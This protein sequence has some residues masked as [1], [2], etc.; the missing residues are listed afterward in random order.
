M[1]I[2]NF[3]GGPIEILWI[4]FDGNL[5]PQTEKSIKPNN[6]A[7]INSYNTHKFQIRFENGKPHSQVVVFT[8]GP[9][10]E[11]ITVFNEDNVLSIDQVS[12][13]DEFQ[14]TVSDA[15]RRLP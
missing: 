10:E 1:Q 13:Y 11:V 8:K 7:N 12:K 4:G 2:R 6:E 3:A 15:T 9:Y 5:V 14:D